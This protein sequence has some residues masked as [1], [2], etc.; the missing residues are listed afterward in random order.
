MSH[1]GEIA[2][3]LWSELDYDLDELDSYGGGDHATEDRVVALLGQVRIQLDSKKVGSPERQ[4]TNGRAAPL[5]NRV[6][7]EIR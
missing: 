4:G 3:A 2:L 6:C 5:P 1:K 7:Q